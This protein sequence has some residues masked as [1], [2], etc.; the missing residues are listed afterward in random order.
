MSTTR[1]AASVATAVLLVLRGVRVG[2]RSARAGS[3]APAPGSR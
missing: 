3:A 2:A 1:V